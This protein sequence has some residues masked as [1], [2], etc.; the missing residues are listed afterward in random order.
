MLTYELKITSSKFL[1]LVDLISDRPDEFSTSI[2]IV[3]ELREGMNVAVFPFMGTLIGI[4][5][6]LSDRA[7]ER[8]PS[9]MVEL[10][11]CLRLF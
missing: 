5:M 6:S 4:S 1:E 7:T 11:S 3:I 8:Q 10:S 2:P 9:Q